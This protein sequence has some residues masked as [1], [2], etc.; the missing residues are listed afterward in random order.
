[1][2][3]KW[4]LTKWHLGKCTW[5]PHLKA[6]QVSFVKNHLRSCVKSK[7][8]RSVGI[9]GAAWWRSTTWVLQ[10][11]FWVNVGFSKQNR[12]VEEVII[13]MFGNWLKRCD[14]IVFYRIEYD[15]ELMISWWS[16]WQF[17][18]YDVKVSLVICAIKEKLTF[19]PFVN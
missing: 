10:S 4:I 18:V 14:H 16:L 13:Q 9:W 2:L 5:L 6:L 1:M 12:N 11:G 17:T 8:D 7:T 3:S 15:E 19:L